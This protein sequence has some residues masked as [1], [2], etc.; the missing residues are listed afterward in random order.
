MARSGFRDARV[1]HALERAGDKALAD[2][3]ALARALYDEAQGAGADE[4]NLAARRAQAAAATG[5][6]DAAAR[7]LDDLFA[8]ENAPDLRRATNVAASVW[9]RRGML[10]R[11]VEAY[12]W[13][14]SGAAGL[15]APLA[16][17]AMIGIGDRAGAAEMS[18][19]ATTGDCPS[20][21]AA[22]ADLMGQGI[23]HSL[24]AR[25]F[26]ALPALIRAS[27]AL[28]ASGVTTAPLP[29]TPAALAALVALH[30]GEL[31][32]SLSVL[33]AAI[34]ANQGG[35]AALPRLSLL[36]GWTLM[37][38]DQPEPARDARSHALEA[39]VPLAPRDELLLHALDAGLARRTDDRPALVRAWKQARERLL[40]VSVDLYCL[41]PLGELLVTSARL[42][43]SS[44]LAPHLAEA[45]SLLTRLG[46]PPLW[47]VPLRW[48]AVQAAI[49]T[50]RPREIAPHATALVHAAAGSRMASAFSAAGR[51][52]MS[53]LAGTVDAAAVES[54]ARELASVGLTWDGSRLAGHAAAHAEDRR[55]MARLLSC[56]RDLHPATA[57]VR[58]DGPHDAPT[59]SSAPP[60]PR[61]A[62]ATGLSPRER[63]VARLVLEGKTYREIGETIFISPR[64]AEHHIARIR[65]RVGATTRSDLMTRLRVVLDGD[66]QD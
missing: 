58:M 65:R 47:S 32:V 20:L 5:D 46:E 51:C 24:E 57:L 21:L 2:R 36:R 13:P 33:D 1:A 59:T 37:Q 28:T 45:W 55:D 43:E 44:R 6:L 8:Q 16:T 60:A 14:G 3:P 66:N 42:R 56:A 52:W 7:I 22:A 25:P 48:C 27:D 12:R 39:G 26:H 40:H 38:L 23:T 41:L 9:A 4:W 31:D 11:G 62:D 18:A 49:L 61:P 30:S 63:E 54:A 53:V 10:H 34:A 19:S 35:P 17:V 50:D 15:S 29:D 64:T